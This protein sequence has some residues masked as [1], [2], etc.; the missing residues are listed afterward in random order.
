MHATHSAKRIPDRADPAWI[1][2]S[3]YGQG[4]MKL[5]RTN[6]ARKGHEILRARPSANWMLSR[7]PSGLP[8]GFLQFPVSVHLD[9]KLSLESRLN[10]LLTALIGRSLSE[11]FSFSNEPTTVNLF[12]AGLDHDL[13]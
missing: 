3:Q 6:E 1:L 7:G 8:F 12:G 13:H 10:R 2:R 9:L 5:R 4:R 11:N